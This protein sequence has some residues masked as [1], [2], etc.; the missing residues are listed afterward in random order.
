VFRLLAAGKT[1]KDIAKSLNLG[2]ETVRSYRKTMMKKLA[3]NDVAGVTLV[4]GLAGEASSNASVGDKRGHCVAENGSALSKTPDKMIV[5]SSQ[6][7]V[8]GRNHD[9]RKIENQFFSAMVRVKRAEI[10][11]R[12]P[13]PT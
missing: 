2:L 4:A 3:V 5:R 10:R 13:S 8:F 12:A 6:M 11:T 9:G 1:S 7:V